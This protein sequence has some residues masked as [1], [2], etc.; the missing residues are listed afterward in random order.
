MANKVTIAT[1]RQKIATISVM[2]S[3]IL[4]M[5]DHQLFT[6][7]LKK[8][9]E[10]EIENGEELKRF[11]TPVEIE[12]TNLQAIKNFRI[13]DRT[14]GQTTELFRVIDRSQLHATE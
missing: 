11:S 2:I 4:N 14:N 8:S 10:R 12:Y 5:I 6:S 7:H 9:L 1:Y 13:V 3:N